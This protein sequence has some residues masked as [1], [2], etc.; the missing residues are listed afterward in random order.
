MYL[1]V[2]PRRPCAAEV[3]F[4]R[5]HTFTSSRTVTTKDIP[6]YHE[7]F[8]PTLSVLKRL[9][10]SGSITELL[11]EL[12]DELGLSDEVAELPHGDGSYTEIG[13]RSAWARTY[14]KKAGLLDNS[15]R[16]IWALTAEGLKT[17]RVNPKELVRDVRQRDKERR[18]LEGGEEGDDEEGAEG[19]WE[20]QLLA[21]LGAMDP[22][23]F[24]RLCQRL[25]RES[26]FTEVE[27]TKRSGDGGIDGHGLIRIGGLISFP[28][29]FQSKRNAGNIGPDVVRDFRGAMMGRADKGLIITTGGFTREARREATRDGAPP[30]DLIDGQLLVVK[31]KELGLGVQV[32]TRQVEEVR[33]D[34]DWFGTV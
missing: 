25:L 22:I 30:I 1:R 14:L 16:G 27:V 5:S 11:D 3:Q 8:N 21:V 26:G 9:G 10:G 29:L 23:A 4:V 15:E 28:V 6:Q 32:V 12:I 33:V 2:G 34:P 18:E 13:Y 19:G 17:E 7:L 24:E 20:A 31:L